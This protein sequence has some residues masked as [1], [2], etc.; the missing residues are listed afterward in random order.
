MIARQSRVMLRKR[1]AYAPPVPRSAQGFYDAVAAADVYRGD[2]QPANGSGNRPGTTELRHLSVQCFVPI[3]GEDDLGGEPAYRPGY[4]NHEVRRSLNES[5][6]RA[7]APDPSRQTASLLRLRQLLGSN[8]FEGLEA[9]FRSFFAGIP[10]EWH[11]RNDIARYEGYY[12]SVFYSCFAAAGLDV[13]VEDSTSRG[14]LDMAVP[15]GGRVYLFECKTVEKEPEGKAM[16][17]L[18]EKGYADKYR[19]LGRPIHLIGVEFSRE[20]RNVAA[21][22]VERAA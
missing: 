2:V 9:L 4:P 20:D 18:K 12:A 13:R 11:T 10:C 8:D 1:P 3:T 22:E 19:R 7:M 16:A 17:Q 6:L 21:F 14:R 5:L 15:Y